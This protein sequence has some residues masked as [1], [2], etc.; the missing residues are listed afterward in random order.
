MQLAEALQGG[1]SAEAR[2]IRYLVITPVGCSPMQQR[3]SNPETTLTLRPLTLTLSRE[4]T[5]PETT[6]PETK[7][8]TTLTLN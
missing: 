6:H 8:E 4:T 2:P 5:H 7:P 1:T 3:G